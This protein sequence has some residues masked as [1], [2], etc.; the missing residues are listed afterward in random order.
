MATDRPPYTIVVFE[1]DFFWRSIIVM[2]R[3]RLSFPFSHH[4][5][6]ATSTK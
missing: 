1:H 3:G 2:K 6:T 4:H 5:I